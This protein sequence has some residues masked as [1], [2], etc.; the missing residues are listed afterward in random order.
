MIPRQLRNL[1]PAYHLSALKVSDIRS[2]PRACR[3]VRSR[4][5]VLWKDFRTLRALAN[6]SPNRVTGMNHARPAKGRSDIRESSIQSNFP[7]LVT[8][9]TEA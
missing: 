4:H 3:Q 5:D 7:F 1:W 8:R 6:A 9:Y 2:R